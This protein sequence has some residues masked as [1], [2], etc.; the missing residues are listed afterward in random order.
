MT[1]L[2]RRGE[3]LPAGRTTEEEKA[4]IGGDIAGGFSVKSE[5]RHIYHNG[6]GKSH[7]RSIMDMVFNVQ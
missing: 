2:F 6:D 1:E 7:T 3:V 5:D 4:L